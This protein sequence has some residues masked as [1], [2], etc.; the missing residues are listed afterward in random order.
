MQVF[1]HHRIFSRSKPDFLNF[2]PKINCLYCGFE[3]DC[4]SKTNGVWKVLQTSA[5]SSD[6]F[7]P[8]DTRD[9][10]Y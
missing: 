5:H 7:G 1:L 3:I 9:S 4:I 10:P 6:E 2:Q 8:Y